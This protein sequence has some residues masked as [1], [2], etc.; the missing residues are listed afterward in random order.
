MD[1]HTD[2]HKGL[3]PNLKPFDLL[4]VVFI[5][6]IASFFI[7]LGTYATWDYHRISQIYLSPAKRS[8]VYRENTLSKIQG[9]V[10][11]K[12][13][14]RFAEL[15]T[16]PLTLANAVWVHSLALALLH[17]SPEPRVIQ[18]LIDSAELLGR[19]AEAQFYRV[20]FEAAFKAK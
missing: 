6:P 13:Q 19:D 8:A 7:A 5:A 1:F 11:F 9:S 17:F 18:K 10:L 15:T 12:Q 14:V 4:A 20:R 2:V 3:G 16:T